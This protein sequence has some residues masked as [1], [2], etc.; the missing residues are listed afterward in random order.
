MSERAD[1]HIHLFENGFQSGF[2]KR[3]GV[4]IDE[5]ACYT[6]LAADHDVSAALVVGFCGGEAYANN[7]EYLAAMAAE[8]PWANPVAYFVPKSPPDIQ[9]LEARWQQGFVGVSCYVFNEESVDALHR[10]DDAFWS[11]LVDR[12]CIVSVNSNAQYWPAWQH[13]LQ[14][15]GELR[16]VMSHLGAPPQQATAPAP[17]VARGNLATVL[18]LS[19]YPGC[20]VK[21]SGFYALSDPSSDYPH[22]SS[23]PYVEVLLNDFGPGRL[24]WGSDFTP[25]LENL[26]FPQT[27]G[28]FAMMPFLNDAQ[29]Q[30]IEGANL[31]ELLERARA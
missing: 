8:H 31:L 4:N 28:H 26:S 29:R 17:D 14:R 12:G 10:I 15:H 13:I 20:H 6:S 19:A 27:F 11:W 23:W 18:E 30:R 2:T 3:P 1:A 21:L 22:R 7:N 25:C 5:P 16:L 24:L 9:T